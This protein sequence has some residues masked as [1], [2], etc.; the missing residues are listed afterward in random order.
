MTLQR[1]VGA[2][3]LSLIF[4][5]LAA[6][7]LHDGSADNR[8][9]E[10]TT[11]DLM[12]METML[13]T[14]IVA[15]ELTDGDG[16]IVE[17]TRQALDNTDIMPVL[18]E[19]VTPDVVPAQ[20]AVDVEVSQVPSP[21]PAE[22]SIPEPSTNEVTGVMWF[23]QIASF[24]QQENAKQ[25]VRDLKQK[26][27]IAQADMVVGQKGQLYRVRTIPQSNKNKVAETA[28]TIKQHFDITPQILRRSK[29]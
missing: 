15:V 18:T 19:D 21:E 20:P 2:T 29:P 24:S 7:L 22:L 4:I 16:E 12:T 3:V 5:I 13:D 11:D 14:P 26:G 27:I 9:S 1:I 6:L 8:V 25:L 23:L 28:L 17:P 10:L